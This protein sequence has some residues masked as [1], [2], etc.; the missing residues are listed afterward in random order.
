MALAQQEWAKAGNS[1]DGMNKAVAPAEKGAL[2]LLPVKYSGPAAQEFYEAERAAETARQREAA[3]R[4]CG[5]G[6]RRRD[7]A[8]NPG[9]ARGVI[10]A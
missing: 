1:F 2:K 3:A 4:A 6:A 8:V 5:T 7:G 9:T 10:T